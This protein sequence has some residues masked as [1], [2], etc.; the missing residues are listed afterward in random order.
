MPRLT[1]QQ[2]HERTRENLVAAARGEIAAKG[3]AAAS[4]RSISEA[5][6]YSQGAFYSCFERKDAL[7]LYLLED[8]MQSVLSRLGAVPDRIEAKICKLR[9]AGISRLV[10]DEMDAFFDSTSPGTTFANVAVE[11]QL[12][13]NH[14]I[15]F[16]ADYEKARSKF[17]DALGQ[18]M[19]RI[20]GYLP[21]PP[22][23]NPTHLALSLLATGVGFSTVGH[24]M[25]PLERRAILSAFFRGVLA[26]VSE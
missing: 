12:H 25:S 26:R 4:V 9:D 17:Q 10:K 16:A 11:L 5:A 22:D 21:D 19:A 23:I 3:V 7:L 1:R 8:H 15:D 2:S 14:S 24:S 13:A 18:L 20:L 6:G